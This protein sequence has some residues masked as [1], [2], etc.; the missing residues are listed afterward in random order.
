MTMRVGFCGLVQPFYVVD[1][2]NISLDV[3][4]SG[5]DIAFVVV[6]VGFNPCELLLQPSLQRLGQKFGDRL[7]I[8]CRYGAVGGAPSPAR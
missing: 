1:V 5:N 4:A 6:L 3:L 2:R 8:A 7:D